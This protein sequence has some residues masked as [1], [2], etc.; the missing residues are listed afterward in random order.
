MLDVTQ[1]A[2]VTRQ[3][4][5]LKRQLEFSQ[6]Q[7]SDL[8]QASADARCHSDRQEVDVQRLSSHSLQVSQ[9]A[10]GFISKEQFGLN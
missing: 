8:H 5:S 2:V 3:V 7:I 1:S 6:A 4:A 10:Y 9:F